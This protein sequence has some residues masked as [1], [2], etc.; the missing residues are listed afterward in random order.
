MFNFLAEFAMKLI[1]WLHG[2][3]S[4]DKTSEDAKKQPDLKRDLLNRID[5][6]KRLHDK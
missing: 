3:F 6:H 2:L 5:D 1:V 4:A